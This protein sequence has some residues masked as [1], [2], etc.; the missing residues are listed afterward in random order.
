M[1]YTSAAAEANARQLVGDTK[2][3]AATNIAAAKKTIIEN[4]IIGG[5]A[6][7]KYKQLPPDSPEAKE[8][9]AVAQN[10]LFRIKSAE[11]SLKGWESLDANISKFAEKLPPKQNIGLP[12]PS[13]PGV[14]AVGSLVETRIAKLPTIKSPEIVKKQIEAE[15]QDRKVQIDTVVQLAKEQSVDTAKTQLKEGFVGLLPK[16]PAIPKLPILDPK[17]IAQLAYA[18][19]KQEVADFRQKLSKENL[20]KSKE[21]FTFPMKPSLTIPTIPKIPELPKLPNI[22][23]P[24]LPTIALPSIPRIPKIPQLPTIPKLPTIALPTIPKVNIPQLKDINIPSATDI[25]NIKINN[26][27]LP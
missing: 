13:S 20:K 24:Q 11:S 19:A 10:A 9:Y 2:L 22:T 26:I 25:K 14:A 1:A 23:L 3:K 4:K 16:V 18:R 7:E 12:S 6:F 21:A 15:I 27:K 8:L 5:A 17:F